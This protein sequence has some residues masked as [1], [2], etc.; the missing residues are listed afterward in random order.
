VSFNIHVCDATEI[1]INCSI[2]PVSAVCLIGAESSGETA[3]IKSNIKLY[4]CNQDIRL[5]LKIAVNNTVKRRAWA[6]STVFV[7]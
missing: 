1:S 5:I 2:I 7:L 4:H 3:L 6:I